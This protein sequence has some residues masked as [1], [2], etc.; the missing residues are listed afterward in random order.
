MIW[1]IFWIIVVVVVFYLINKYQNRYQS[2]QGNI[3]NFVVIGL[4]L[5][6]VFTASY[7]YINSASDL[8]S[9]K[10]VSD[11]LKLYFTW[12]GG[13]LNGTKDVVGYAVKQDWG[14][15]STNLTRR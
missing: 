12:L 10:G 8:T 13:F 14:L 6:F 9:F 15:N 7:V 4:L 11:F 3:F 2:F 1:I 5:F